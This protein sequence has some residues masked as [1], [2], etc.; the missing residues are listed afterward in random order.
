[1]KMPKPSDMSTPC[2]GSAR[3]ELGT[4]VHKAL[5]EQSSSLGSCGYGSPVFY[6]CVSKE[7]FE[8]AVPVY[9][10]HQDVAK[11]PKEITMK[12]MTCT[13]NVDAVFH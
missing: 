10:D 3:I 9:V 13:R 12:G 11:L 2:V 4:L 6:D 5:G 7:S 1:M 8:G